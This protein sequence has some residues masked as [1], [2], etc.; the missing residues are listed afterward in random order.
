MVI[1]I[2]SLPGSFADGTWLL[3]PGRPCMRPHDAGTTTLEGESLAPAHGL[4][5][6]QAS[7]AA[8]VG[9]LL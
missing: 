7:A 8:A 9:G 5:G 4:P 2:Q 6:V 1:E 3:D